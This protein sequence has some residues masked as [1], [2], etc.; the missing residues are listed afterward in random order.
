MAAPRGRRRKPGVQEP[1]RSRRQTRAAILARLLASDGLY[2]TQ[3]AA[4]CRLTEGSIS[5]ILAELRAEGLIEEPRRP[6]PYPGGPSSIVVL[7]KDERVAALEFAN[8]RLGFGVANLAGEA[9]MVARLPLRAGSPPAAVAAAIEEAVTDLAAWCRRHGVAPRQVAASLPGFGGPAGRPNP[10]LPVD[11]EALAARL[12]AAF[13]GAPVLVGNT[14]A[15]HAAIHLHGRGSPPVTARQL[16]LYLGHGV[17]GAWVEPVTHGDPIQPVELG[18]VVLDPAGAPCR[19]GHRGCLETAA[20]T[21]ALAALCGVAE[22]ALAEAG[23]GWPALVR[24]TPRR[25]AALRD[26]L[27]RT[28]LVI[29]NALNACPAAQVVVCGWPAALPEDLRAAVAQGIDR[30][31]FGGLPADMPPIR[32]LHH[33]PGSEPAAALAYA[34]HGLV[35]QGGMA[36]QDDTTPARLA[37]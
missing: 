30:S 24:L 9:D 31:L 27:V 8:D 21:A 36:P 35:R 15:A 17:G 32:F 19:C 18:H 22:A 11:G 14:V 37:G 33:A 26:A 23:P 29:G 16:F 34:V 5:R 28:G 3:L 12:R 6:I 1:P 10:I 25:L 13:P 20:S 2:R 7:R 4:E